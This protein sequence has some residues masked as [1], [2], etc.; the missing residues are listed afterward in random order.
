MFS[1]SSSTHSFLKAECWN[2]SFPPT[3]LLFWYLHL[4]LNQETKARLSVE[5]KR[6]RNTWRFQLRPGCHLVKNT[7]RVLMR[8]SEQAWCTR[9]T[10]GSCWRLHKSRANHGSPWVYLQSL[11]LTLPSRTLSASLCLQTRLATSAVRDYFLLQMS[12]VLYTATLAEFQ[13]EIHFR[14]RSKAIKCGVYHYYGY[15]YTCLSS[16]AAERV[17]LTIL[18]HSSFANY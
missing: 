15:S 9:S 13:T 16:P 2:V 6:Y 12:L 10:G 18:G 8:K 3:L 7:D 11:P 14:K 1:L 5:V 17:L 4:I